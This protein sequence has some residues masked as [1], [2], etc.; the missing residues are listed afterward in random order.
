MNWM[1]HS[2]CFIIDHLRYILLE[3]QIKFPHM[4]SGLVSNSLKE[5]KFK[6]VSGI[7]LVLIN[8]YHHKRWIRRTTLICQ[9]TMYKCLSTEICARKKREWLHD[10]IHFH[11]WITLCDPLLAE[12]EL[13]INI[14]PFE[15]Q[16]CQLN[17]LFHSL[18]FINIH[19]LW[20]VCTL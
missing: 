10:F 1:K 15:L 18:T 11:I 14:Y 12:M 2:P 4:T 8:G 9:R 13:T 7:T 19:Y 20:P 5:F 3:R 17:D 6:L 16:L